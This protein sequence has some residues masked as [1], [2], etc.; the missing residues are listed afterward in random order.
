MA[1][2]ESEVRGILPLVIIRSLVF[3]TFA[4]SVPFCNYGGVC[5]DDRDCENLLVERARE[6]AA[7]ARCRYVEL[8]Q[9]N[10][11]VSVGKIN[12]DAVTFVLELTKDCQE[13]WDSFK[14]KVRNQ[15][16]KAEKSG[17]TA[18]MGREYLDE[19]YAVYSHNMRDLGTPVHSR[20]LFATLLSEFGESLNILTVWKQK[21]VIAAML[22]IQ[23]KD[24]LFDLWASSLRAYLEYCPNNLLYWDIIRYG[25]R[26]GLKYFDFGRSQRGSGTFRFKRQW[27]AAP[28]QLSYQVICH[29]KNSRMPNIDPTKAKYRLFTFLW[30]KMP[31]FA[32]DLLGPR[33]RKDV[34]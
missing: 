12:G 18:K 9:Y 10:S 31:L 13:L 15:V 8:R 26:N 25:C 27:G 4:V 17:L 7:K 6:A 5:A 14:P 16:R 30:S 28:K 21:T 22:V 2:D 1:M 3:G 33:L 20:K 32:A 23:F 11:R 29:G 34:P 24:S 19:F